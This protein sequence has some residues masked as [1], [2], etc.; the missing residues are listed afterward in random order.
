MEEIR[1]NDTAE[2]IFS[3]NI[4]LRGIVSD[5]SANRIVFLI[6]DDSVAEA[7][8]IKA[9]SNLLVVVNTDYGLKKTYSSVIEELDENGCIT[10][11]N[12]PSVPVIQ[13]RE[14]VRI[15]SDITFKIKKDG[16]LFNCTCL[17][18]SGGGIAFNT[19]ETYFKLNERVQIIFQSKDFEQD[20]AVEAIIHLIDK[21][22]IVARYVGLNKYDEAKIVKYVFKKSAKKLR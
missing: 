20:I 19:S 22:K 21:N 9:L 2:L 12:N 1:R 7:R 5:F 11:E 4:T 3:D 8:K 13:K 17:N 15:S 6:M 10:V 16:M 14:F 18:I